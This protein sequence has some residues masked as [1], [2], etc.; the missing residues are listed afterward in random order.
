MPTALFTRSAPRPRP[1]LVLAGDLALAA[2]RVH[3]AAGPARWSFAA[4]LAGR[5][6]GPI[7]WIAPAW[8]GERLSAEGARGFFDPSRLLF[9]MP[10]RAEDLLWVMEEALRAGVLALVVAELPEPPGLTRV[11]RLQLAAEAGAAAARAPLGLLLTPG[12][13][14]A[15]GVESR[16]HIAPRHGAG[17]TRWRIERRRARNAGP[18]GWT[19]VQER[20]ALHCGAAPAPAL[21]GQGA[22]GGSDGKP[23]RT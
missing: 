20:G 6:E 13:G 18:R 19:L 2:G 22:S 21:P 17:L 14:G 12:E 9:A 11:R 10:G 3:E 4:M 16:W 7:L 23:A 8:T 1:G 5:V 15:P